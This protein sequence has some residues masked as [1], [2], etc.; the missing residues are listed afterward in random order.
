MLRLDGVVLLTVF[1]YP[2]VVVQNTVLFLVIPGLYQEIIQLLIIFL[3]SLENRSLQLDPT[4]Y[5][6]Y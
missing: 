4:G 2:I 5:G 6:R 1:K 3:G